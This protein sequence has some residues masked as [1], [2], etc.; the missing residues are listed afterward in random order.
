MKKSILL[1]I[2]IMFLGLKTYGQQYLP[3]SDTTFYKSHKARYLSTHKTLKTTG[4]VSLGTGLPLFFIGLLFEVGSIESQHA[5][6]AA[7]TGKWMATSGAALTL[8]SIPC[9]VIS[10]HYKKKAASLSLSNQQVFIPQQNGLIS[11]ATP[12]L[13]LKIPF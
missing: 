3:A 11:R 9:F 2:A 4:W 8:A 5:E 13:S 7:K 10:H 1:P 12:T 6:G